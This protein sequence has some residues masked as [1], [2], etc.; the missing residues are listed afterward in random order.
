M[1]AIS[2]LGVSSNDILPYLNPVAPE[3]EAPSVN[4]SAPAQSAPAV[5][6]PAIQ[7]VPA[8]VSVQPMLPSQPVVMPEHVDISGIERTVEAILAS[9]TNLVSHVNANAEQPNV[10]LGVED[11]IPAP[12]VNVMPVVPST[13]VS[14]APVVS[15]ADVSVQPLFQSS[16]VVNVP[17]VNLPEVSATPLNV[18]VLNDMPELS[19]VIV[20]AIK[21]IGNKNDAIQGQAF[22]SPL[23]VQP[24]PVSVQPPDVFTTPL[25][26]SGFR[27]VMLVAPQNQAPSSPLLIQHSQN[28]AV[29]NGQ[30]QVRAQEQSPDRP[31]NV[32]NHVDVVI[33]GK[34]VELYIDG[35]RVGSAVLRWTERQS[36]RSGVSEF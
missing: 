2:E 7:T 4:I 5:N 11:R 31:V 26:L 36:A 22:N 30:A 10:S 20:Q 13:N 12:T 15:P 1:S 24:A 27:N 28:Q 21:S 6:I 32:N 35:E 17:P 23:S 18:S 29:M 8:D 3:I 14:V 9:F 16:P 19:N 33:E 34:P 25:D